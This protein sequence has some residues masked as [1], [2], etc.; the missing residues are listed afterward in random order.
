[1]NGS[2]TVTA[3]AWPVSPNLLQYVWSLRDPRVKDWGI[4]TDAGFM[5]PLLISY[6][7]VSK[8]GGPRWMKNRPA[9]E[10]KGVI[11]LYNL[12]MMVANARFVAKFLKHSYLGGGY[13]FLCQGIDY[14]A[15]DDT[16]MT[17]LST[18]WWYAFVRIADFLDTV[19][20]V[21]RKKNSH[22]T[23]LH[24]MHHFTVVLDCWIWLNFGHD[25]QVILGVCV[26]AS[27]HV[28]MY[29]YYFLAALGPAVR[30]HLWWKR[31]LTT[32]Q[33]F[34]MVFVV[35]HMQIPLFYDCGY[36]RA[37]CVIE[38]LQLCGGIWLFIDF[39][40]KTYKIRDAEGSGMKTIVKNV[41]AG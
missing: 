26:N 22:V 13:S 39:Y 27:V 14:S 21:L 18:A 16:T 23:F 4:T 5:F 19:F 35:A 36:P 33:I 30:K 10:L 32:L 25:G 29:G 24:V 7:Y 31:H 34:Q 15:V 9:F 6:I 17:L 2:L 40:L 11:L 20:F 8:I 1:M 28:V 3:M 37:F 12:F 41:K 38:I